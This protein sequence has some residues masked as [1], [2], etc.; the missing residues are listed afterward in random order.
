MADD[1]ERFREWD[2]RQ[3]A[4]AIR[5]PEAVR[6][7]EASG[8]DP[9]AQAN[10]NKAQW[11]GEDRLGRRPAPEAPSEMRE[12]EPGISGNRRN[13]GVQDWASGSP[14][15]PAA[16][17]GGGAKSTRTQAARLRAELIP[18]DDAGFV[19]EYER[20][21]EQVVR[22]GLLIN[23]PKAAARLEVLMRAAGY[24][25]ISVKVERTIDEALDHAARWTVRRDG[26]GALGPR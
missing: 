10:W 14:N 3:W 11:V 12:G 20:A 1:S 4:S 23:G 26:A 2:R 21:Y 16:S 5:K 25:D 22:E 9:G 8:A 6:N 24:A 7:A 18:W 17:S 15:E 19:R 13:P